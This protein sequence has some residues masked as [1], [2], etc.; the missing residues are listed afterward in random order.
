MHQIHVKVT[1]A[2]AGS[3]EHH[4]RNTSLSDVVEFYASVETCTVEPLNDEARAQFMSE[5]ASASLPCLL[6]RQAE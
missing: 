1:L 2:D 5:Y 3:F 6:Q 4:F